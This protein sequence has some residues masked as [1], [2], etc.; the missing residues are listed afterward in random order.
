MTENVPHTLFIIPS[1]P[2]SIDLHP[3]PPFHLYHSLASVPLALSLS[4][5]SPSPSLFLSLN[6]ARYPCVGCWNSVNG[7]GCTL[8]ASDRGA[9]CGGALNHTSPR[10]P[11]ATNR[12]P[13]VTRPWWSAAKLYDVISQMPANRP[14]NM[15]IN[16]LNNP[17]RLSFIWQSRHL[18][19][20]AFPMACLRY[21]E[22]F[23]KVMKG[24][25]PALCTCP[26][27]RF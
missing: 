21:I 3:P 23:M 5:T 11:K 2:L 10:R 19:A 27:F 1:P 8:G 20:I 18:K 17:L 4:L 12:L 14:I 16:W 22:W 13:P 15:Q 25:F 26:G 9:T 7:V 6:A 24:N